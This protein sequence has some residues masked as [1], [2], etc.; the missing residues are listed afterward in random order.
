MREENNSY[1]YRRMEPHEYRLLEGFMYEAIFI[2][3]GMERLPREIIKEPSIAR[4]ING[5]GDNSRGDFCHVCESD[6]GIVGAAWSRILDADGEEGYGNIGEG[7]PELAISV[8]PE[9]RDQGIGAELIK[10]L[11]K[12]LAAAGYEKISLSVQKGNDA[13]HLYQRIGYRL[14]EEKG[15]DF[16]MVCELKNYD[17][18]QDIA[19]A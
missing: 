6:A 19:S 4:Y 9:Y 16:I 15:D 3:A 17:S 14:F 1:I 18:S 8:L 12:T 10:R 13:V 7:I 2:P 5:F 11:H